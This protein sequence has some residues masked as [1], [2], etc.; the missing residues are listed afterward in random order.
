MND[1]L[2]YLFTRNSGDL[3]GLKMCLLLEFH[4]SEEAFFQRKCLENN[5]VTELFNY[6]KKSNPI[7]TYYITKSWINLQTFKTKIE[8]A[9]LDTGCLE[10]LLT[11]PAIPITKVWLISGLGQC[12]GSHM[13][14]T[15]TV[16]RYRDLSCSSFKSGAKI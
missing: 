5:F 8:D 3:H 4:R 7:P 15:I 2:W 13:T 16:I 14:I 1:I 12:Q 9:L 11:L 10:R 6:R